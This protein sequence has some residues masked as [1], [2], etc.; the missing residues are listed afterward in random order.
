MK[1]AHDIAYALTPKDVTALA[2][3]IINHTELEATGRASY[4][5]SLLA[6]V[7]IELTGKPVLRG[8]RGRRKPLEPEAVIAAFQ[9]VN[10]VYYAAVL[11]AVPIEATPAERQSKTGFARSAASTLRRALALGWDVLTPLPDA[12]KTVLGRWIMDHRQ[13]RVLTAAQATTRVAAMAERVRALLTGLPK[14]EADAIMRAA[15]E[16]MTA[17]R[18]TPVSLRR[19]E[20]PP[21]RIAAH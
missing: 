15:F 5:R 7:Q 20:R 18:L 12:S 11:E 19:H 9:K 2:R 17:Q 6:G 21:E 8:L 16:E 14:R 1:T 13:P 3:T 10:A 4:L